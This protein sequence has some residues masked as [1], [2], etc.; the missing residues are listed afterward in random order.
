MEMVSSTFKVR[1]FLPL[2]MT[3][4]TECGGNCFT[5]FRRVILLPATRP[6]T[7]PAQN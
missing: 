3:S 6:Q 5:E 2:T 7:Q 4:E 1:I